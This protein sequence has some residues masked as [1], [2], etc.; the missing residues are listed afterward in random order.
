[1]IHGLLS[2]AGV[3]DAGKTRIKK[4]GTALDKALA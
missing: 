2:M 3:V 4:I 1:M